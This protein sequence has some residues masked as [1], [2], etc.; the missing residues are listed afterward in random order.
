MV[1]KIIRNKLPANATTGETITV[2]LQQ[3]LRARRGNE[4]RRDRKA[5][6]DDEV[7]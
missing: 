4:E 5:I 1:P 2:L 3:R 7:D 6:E